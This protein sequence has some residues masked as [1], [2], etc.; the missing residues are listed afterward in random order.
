MWDSKT[1]FNAGISGVKHGC[2]ALVQLPA[3]LCQHKKEEKPLNSSWICF[4][5]A[6]CRWLPWSADYSGCVC[7]VPFP[8]QPLLRRRVGIQTRGRSALQCRVTQGCV[9]GTFHFLGLHM[10][11]ISAHVCVTQKCS[12]LLFQLWMYLKLLF[13]SNRINSSTVKE[14]VISLP[15]F[16]LLFSSPLDLSS[17]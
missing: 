17:R 13:F 3:L 6:N 7:L 10:K 4:W 9:A 12:R 11:V 5:I 15:F 8:P 16:T 1:Q 14:W 2:V